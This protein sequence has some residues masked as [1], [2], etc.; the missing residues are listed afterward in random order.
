M[1]I[2]KTLAGEIPQK[3]LVFISHRTTDC[4]VADMLL[5]FLSAT[6]IPREC[7]KCSSL[8]GNDVQEKISTEVR[9]WIEH[10]V[11]NIAILSKDYYESAYCLNEAG[12]LW[13]LKD[14]AVIPIALPEIDIKNMKG[15]L[16]SDYKLRRLDSD[17]DIAAIYDSAR[18]CVGVPSVKHLIVTAEIAKLKEKYKVFCDKRAVLTE[19]NQANDTEEDFVQD[20]IYEDGYHEVKDYDGNIIE[21]G[22]FVKGKLVEGI[23]YNIILKISKEKNGV[24]DREPTEEEAEEIYDGTDYDVWKEKL[25]EAPV[26]KDEIK[27]ENWKYYELQKYDGS[28]LFSY[29]KDYIKKLGLDYFYVVD[30]K[31]QLE[32]DKIK[33][34]FTNFRT[35]ESFLAEHNPDALQYLK[36]GRR[37]YEEAD[38]AD[39]E[40]D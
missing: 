34:K 22:Q 18:E 30:K 8:P 27:N 28:L 23:S 26:S 5:D 33:P 35:L 9:E 29:T 19:C 2:Q 6:G 7:I 1:N 37:G 40:V 20:D 25:L 38:C 36:T 10:S 12:I 17:I 21:K 32:D 14:T 13:F 11:L 24:V 4:Q 16:N 3:N 15:F 39:I 31:V